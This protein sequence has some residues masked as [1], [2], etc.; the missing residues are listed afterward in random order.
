MMPNPSTDARDKHSCILTYDETEHWMQAVW[1]GFI[2]PLGAQ[3]G[4]DAYLHHA[5]QRPSPY[6]LN[7]NSRL[8][9]PWFEGLEWL[10]EVWMPEATRLGLRYVA[11][12]Q[13]AAW[14]HD[15]LLTSGACQLPFDLQIFR[16]VEDAKAWLR[17]MRDADVA[18][19][20]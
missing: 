9:G 14:H 13:Q 4:A 7:D 17:H 16:E 3:R 20:P 15:V 1:Y 2:D 18:E 8:H 10:R 11:H 5:T 12:I 19:A 6:L